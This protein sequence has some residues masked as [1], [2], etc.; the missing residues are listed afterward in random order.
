[1][2]SSQVLQSTDQN[3][4][5]E[6]A[7]GSRRGSRVGRVVVIAALGGCALVAVSMQ[8]PTAT[9]QSSSTAVAIN[10]ITMPV[11]RNATGAES[12]QLASAY[13]LPTQHTIQG[14]ATHGNVRTYE[15][16]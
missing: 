7:T 16:D 1:M 11:A 5:G 12:T 8:S 15:H 14:N 4:S 13:Y 10:T 3:Q 6:S 2:Q 9:N